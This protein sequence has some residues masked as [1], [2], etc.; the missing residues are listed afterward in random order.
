[1]KALV[2]RYV[3]TAHSEHEME[4]VTEDDIHELKSDFSSWRC[5][6]LEILKRNGMD[7]GGADLTNSS[8]LF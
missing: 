8:K 3:V 4:P 7:T 5:E 2:W 1:M 6:L